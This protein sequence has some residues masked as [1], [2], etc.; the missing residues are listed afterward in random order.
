M[1]FQDGQQPKLYAQLDRADA[2]RAAGYTAA[3]IRHSL[4]CPAHKRGQEPFAAVGRC[5]VMYGMYGKMG[6][7]GYPLKI[8][9]IIGHTV[10]RQGHFPRRQ[11]VGNARLR[12]SRGNGWHTDFGTKSSV[13]YPSRRGTGKLRGGCRSPRSFDRAEKEERQMTVSSS[14][15]RTFSE[16]RGGDF[17][18]PRP[19]NDNR[20]N[21]DGL[22]HFT[23]CKAKGRCC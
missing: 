11:A 9:Y 13:L 14:V 16:S 18:L 22:R 20:R 17:P 10:H 8:P 21:N 15:G 3:E 23:I 6:R 5:T 7:E 1:S 19:Q 12:E 4:C 2:E